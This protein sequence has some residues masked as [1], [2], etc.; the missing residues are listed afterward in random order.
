MKNWIIAFVILA[1]LGAAGWFGYQE[2]ERRQRAKELEDLQMVEAGRGNLVASIGATGQVRS[3]QTAVLSWQTSGIVEQVDGALGEQVGAGQSIASLVRTSLPQNVILARAELIN[4]KKALQDLSDTGL[5]LAQAEND[6]AKAEKQVEDLQKRL[7]NID[8]PSSKAD[9]DAA[10]ASVTL[11]K[12]QMD[13]ARKAYK[14]FEN[15]PEDNLIRA[16]L[17]NRLAEAEQKYDATVRRLNNLLGTTPQSTITITEAD[18]NL[19]KA[20]V[21]ELQQKINDLNSGPDPDD[22]AAIQA[23]IDAAQATLNQM[24]LEAP[25]EGTLTEVSVKPGDQVFPGTLALRIDDLSRLLVDVLVSEVDI[26]RVDIGQEVMLTFDAI[27][28]KE[29]RG[30]VSQIDA[31]GESVQGVTEFTVTVELTDVDEFVRPGMTAAVNFIV[32]QIDNV[33]M[34][35]NRAVRTQDGKRV[36]YTLVDDKLVAIEIILGASSDTMSQV[37]RGDLKEGDLIV[38]NPPT[39]FESDGPPSFVR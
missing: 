17:L 18:L 4:A 38:V 33:L 29:Y 5:A 28:G 30:V 24:Y 34:V 39:D 37:L 22:I 14:P 26:N 11:A 15:K 36:V 27:T 16:T 3:N 21:V 10:K 8:L 7:D 35:P 32:E 6:L 31:I 19:A 13:K 25:F 1:I 20:Q 23:R 2:Y 9:I 12:D